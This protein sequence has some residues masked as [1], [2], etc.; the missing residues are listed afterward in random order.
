MLSGFTFSYC[1]FRALTLQHLAHHQEL[2]AAPFSDKIRRSL[3]CIAVRHDVRNRENLLI[4][5]IGVKYL[6]SLSRGRACLS[7]IRI[8]EQTV[9][10]P[11]STFGARRS[12]LHDLPLYCKYIMKPTSGYSLQTRK[13]AQKV[14]LKSPGSCTGKGSYHK[15]RAH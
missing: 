12:I 13:H 9:S 1:A 14:V 3:L 7:T 6:A 15:C 5:C 4:T 11:S 8:E 2:A 10:M